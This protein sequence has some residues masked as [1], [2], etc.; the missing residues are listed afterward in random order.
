MLNAF[1]EPLS[2]ELPP[3]DPE[4]RQPWQR[5]I[6]TSLASPGRY[7]RLGYGAGH[8][9]CHLSRGGSLGR[10][11]CETRRGPDAPRPNQELYLV[12][13]GETEWSRSGRHTGTTDLPLTEDGRKA[14]RLLR[15][16]L[17]GKDLRSRAHEPHEARPGDVRARGARRSSRDR[18]RPDGVGLRRVRGEDSRG[19]REAGAGLVDLRAR[20]PGGESPGAGRHPSR[21]SSSR[22]RARA[23]NVAL[24]AHGHVF[25]ALAARW[26]GLPVS[27]GRHFLLDTGTISILGHYRGN[28]AVKRWNSPPAAVAMMRDA[29]RATGR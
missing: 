4:G 15:P 5:W 14:A 19:D 11:P 24:F 20:L 22:L 7:L 2:F 28:P 3:P 25:R 8:C 1:W 9:R 10:L 29:W 23:G 21:W 18:A 16:A 12:R 26:V 17:E 13:H 27:E 6:D